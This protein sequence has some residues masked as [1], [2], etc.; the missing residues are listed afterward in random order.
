MAAETMPLTMGGAGSVTLPQL[1]AAHCHHPDL[2][3]LHVDAH[4]D[5]RPGAGR[6]AATGT[7]F[8]RAAEEGLVDPQGSIHLGI[9]GTLYSPVY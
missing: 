5:T 4:T 8:A 9:R 7:T 2:V 1:R 6:A 3:V